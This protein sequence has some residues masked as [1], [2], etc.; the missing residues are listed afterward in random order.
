MTEPTATRPPRFDISTNPAA[1]EHRKS[2][3]RG[4]VLGYYADQFDIYL[5]IITLAPAMIYFQSETTSAATEALIAAFVFAS[6]LIARPLGSA[7]FGQWA[8]RAGRR[9]PHWLPSPASESRSPPL[10]CFP[11][12]SMLATGRSRC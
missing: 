7:F 1:E 2:A 5:P 9:A 12:S 10:H 11:A 4:G 6:T 8:D 3:I